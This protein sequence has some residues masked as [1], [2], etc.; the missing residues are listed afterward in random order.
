[1]LLCKN[2]SVAS[3]AMYGVFLAEESSCDGRVVQ[4]DVYEAHNKALN[5]VSS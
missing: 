2:L 3:A 1:M 4:R 5:N